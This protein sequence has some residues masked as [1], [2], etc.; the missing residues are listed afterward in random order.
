MKIAIFG[1]GAVG[2]T[3]GGWLA[4]RHADLWLVDLPE[5]AKKLREIGITLYGHDD[6]EQRETSKVQAVE[7]LADIPGGPDVVLVCVKNYSLDSVSRMIASQL[8][9]DRA[10]VVGFQNGV[11]NQAILPKHFKRVAYGIVGYNCWVDSVGVAGFQKKGPLVLGVLDSGVAEDTRKLAAILNAGVETVFTDHLQDAAHTKMVVNLTNSLTTLVGHRFK[12]ISDPAI[13]QKLL[14]HL[15]AEGTR[16]VEAAGFHELRIGGMPSWM[17]MRAAAVLPRFLTKRKFEQN[18]KKMVVSSM[19]QDILQRGGTDSELD[20]LNG[21]FV[22][23]ADRHGVAA[24]YNRAVYELCKERF[25]KPG[26][27][28]MDV[29]EVWTEVQA[30]A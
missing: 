28:P 30:R 7:K 9:A 27:Q 13:F 20:S 29:R 23:L 10:L 19:A 3:I 4:P 14:S 8:G 16:I 6:P 15:T 2:S 17:L 1:A 24:P 25:G 18:V 21:Y 5:T 22:Q 11:E 12:P 26:F